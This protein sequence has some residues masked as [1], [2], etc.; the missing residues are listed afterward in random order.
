MSLLDDLFAMGKELLGGDKAADQTEAIKRNSFDRND[1]NKVLKVAPKI[2]EMQKNLQRDVDYAADFMGDLHASCFKIEPQLRDAEEMKPTHVAN[3]AVIEQLMNMPEMHNLRQHSA[4]DP[5]GAASAMV[6]LQDSAVETL[7]KVHE[8]AEEAAE[9]EQKRQEEREA[10]QK[11]IEDLIE[12]LKNNPPP[13]E[14]PQNP[15]CFPIPLPPDPN[16]QTPQ[17]PQQNDPRPGQLQAKIDQGVPQPGGNGAVQQAA[18]GAAEGHGQKMRAVAKAASEQMDQEKQLM[19]ASGDLQKMNVKDRMELAAKL[20]NN[21]MAKFVKLLGQFK[22]VQEAESRKRVTDAASEVVGITVGDDL[23]RMA[24]SELLNFADE[25]LEDLMWQR[26]SEQQMAVNDMKGKEKQG[27]GPIIC[28]VDESWSMNAEDVIGGTRE[29]WSKALALALC[30][31]ARRRNRDF[32]YIGF[33]SQ[34][35]QHVVEFLN[36]QTTVDKVIAMTEHFFA[37]GTH[38]EEPLKLAL[39][40]METTFDGKGKPKPDIVF[41]TDDEYGEMDGDFMAEWN[42][43]KDKT[44]LKCYGVSIGC[45]IGGALRAVSDNVREINELTSDPRHV[46]DL[47]RTI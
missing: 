3:R 28:V 29:A 15:G 37:G 7:K 45:S 33:G 6:A 26:W 25:A 24:T 34:G 2:Q 18:Q 4:G 39:H 42:R 9:Q 19:Q 11:E 14:D 16:G 10:K 35:E 5:Y 20:Q 43:V 30:D 12:E 32:V 21:R 46:G 47:F 31:Q 17:G 44:S 8:A 13:A 27:Q 36:G 22:M 40:I 1:W 38:Y 41:I 23:S